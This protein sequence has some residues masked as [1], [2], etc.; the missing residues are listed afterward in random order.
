[1][2]GPGV[3]WYKHVRNDMAFVIGPPF[4]EHERFKADVRVLKLER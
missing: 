1:M 3:G 4:W 2:N